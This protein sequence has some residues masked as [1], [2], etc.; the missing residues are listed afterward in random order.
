[1]SE[2]PVIPRPWAQRW[3]DFRLRAM[4][5]VV[6]GVALVCTA[7]LWNKNWGPMTF[8]GEVEG[9]RATVV[10]TQ[11]GYLAEVGVEQY[12]A[13]RRGDVVAVVRVSSD[14]TLEASLEAIRTEMGVMRVRMTQDQ[15]RNR[16]NYQQLRFDWLDQRVALAVARANLQFAE[17]ELSRMERLRADRIS[18]E[19]EY[20]LALDQRD[21][22]KVEVAE[23]ARLVDEMGAAVEGMITAGAEEGPGILRAITA[24]I[25]AQE[26]QLEQTEGAIRLR[27]PIDGVV[28]SIARR[29]GEAIMAG[30]PLVEIAG[31]QPEWIKGYIR[32]PI[33]FQPKQGD[34]VEVRTRGNSRQVGMAQVTAVGA[35]L[36]LFSQ[37][38]RIR[39]FDS[40]MERG[41]PVLLDV[42]PDMRLYPGELVDLYLKSAN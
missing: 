34:Q 25:E 13:V 7:W 26:A 32:Q 28:T 6:F 42:P 36:E 9:P 24:A 4:P 27:A 3:N 38:L 2:L 39:G 16:Q 10:C 40:S 35:R 14:Q 37:S 15:Q 17:S 41:L 29:P 30:E 19:A 23:R 33:G 20:E 5:F 8:V 21:A 31:E 18:S 12:A 11:A 22:L 1:M